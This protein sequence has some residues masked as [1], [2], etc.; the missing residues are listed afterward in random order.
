MKVL[1]IVDD[2]LIDPLGIGYLSSYLKLNSID[3][4]IVKTKKEDIDQKIKDYQPDVFAYSVTTGKHTY[5]KELNKKLKE[6]YP[7]V[8][9]VFGGPHVTF[10]PQYIDSPEMNYGIRGEGFRVFP[11]LIS[12]LDSCVNKQFMENVVT[13]DHISPLRPMLDKSDLLFPDRELMYKYPE[14]RNNPI[15]NVMTSFCCLY[16]CGYCFNPKYKEMYGIKESEIRPVDSVIEEIRQLKEYP[17]KLIFFQDDIFPIY[18]RDWLSEFCDKY[19][20]NIPFH[21]QIRIEMLNED[22]VKDLKAVGLHGV[23]FAIESGNEVLRR[24][25]LG[26]QI[27]D[28]TIYKGAELLRKHGIKFRAENMI[29]IPDE[30]METALQTLDMNLKCKPTIAW[31]SVFQPYPG[32]SLGDLYTNTNID[33]ITDSFFEGYILNVP[34]HKQYSRLQKLFPVIVEN[35]F[36]RRYTKLLVNMPLDNLYYKL[37]LWYKKRLYMQKLYAV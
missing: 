14:N 5:Y 9:S 26:R 18:K 30:S 7:D 3:V 16:N 19:D 6:K 34:N 8:V 22:I 27:A 31:A 33:E 21:I 2:Y 4:D 24:S 36:L 10:F 25:V 20:F 13:A 35:P 17:L 15:K 28:S 37:F 29:G 11:E 23:T 32:T 12:A 1:F